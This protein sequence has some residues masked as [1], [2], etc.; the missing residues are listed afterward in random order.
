MLIVSP[1]WPG[2]MMYKKPVSDA[3]V[4]V[5]LNMPAMPSMGMGQMQSVV[6]LTWNGSEYAGEGSIAMAGPWNV[7][8]EAHR[9]GQLIGSYKTHFDAK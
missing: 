4:Q 7:T 1:V 3:Q 2:H 9:R 8:V 6:N 5:T